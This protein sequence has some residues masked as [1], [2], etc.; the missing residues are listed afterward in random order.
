P[1]TLLTPRQSKGLEFD[2]VVLVEP[3]HVLAAGA[4]DLYV[5]M[6]R[7]TQQLRVVHASPLPDGLVVGG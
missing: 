5:A 4:G 3:A 7:P 2:V 6:T 1:L